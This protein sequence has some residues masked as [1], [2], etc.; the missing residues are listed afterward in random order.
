MARLGFRAIFNVP[1]SPEY[2]PIEFAFAKIKARFRSLRARKLAGLWVIE[3]NGQ[4]AYLAWMEFCQDWARHRLKQIYFEKYDAQA[5]PPRER[6]NPCYTA[7]WA[8]EHGMRAPPYRTTSE[9]D[10]MANDICDEAWDQGRDIRG[11][12]VALVRALQQRG[13]L[14]NWFYQVVAG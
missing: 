8:W 3:D 13:L 6:T 5:E 4:D 9:L 7:Q 1:Y 11:H 2:N 14:P 12:L 10:R